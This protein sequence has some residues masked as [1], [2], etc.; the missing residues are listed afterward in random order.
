LRGIRE[1]ALTIQRL[2]SDPE[3]GEIRLTY[4]VIFPSYRRKGD[5]AAA[6]NML[7]GA[8]FRSFTNDIF[9]D[10]LTLFVRERNDVAVRLFSKIGF[11]QVGIAKSVEDPFADI[12]HIGRSL[13]LEYKAKK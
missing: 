13:K 7:V 3:R 8:L 2:Q 9:A 6:L 4:L 1:R 11:K 12:E 10:K 5:G